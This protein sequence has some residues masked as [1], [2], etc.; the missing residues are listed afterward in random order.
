MT[1]SF[2]L[3]PALDLLGGRV[4]R[5]RQGDFSAITTYDDPIEA[6]VTTAARFADGLH[7][8]DLDGA[9]DGATANA[10]LIERL[11]ALSPVPIEVGGGLRTEADVARALGQGMARVILGSRAVE[12]PGF[13]R[14]MVE[15]YGPARIVVGADL[16]DGRPAVRGWTASAALT[17]DA[18]LQAMREAGVETVIVTDVATDGMMEGPNTALL[19]RLASA[20]PDLRIIASGGVASVADLD[21]L[22]A[23]GTAGAVFGRAW[24]DGVL[25]PDDLIA[26]R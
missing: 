12:D 1:S 16:R 20:F 8:V 19:G 15:E 14:A 18:F 23:A 7:V 26:F 25:A 11:V 5:L 3:W 2:E 13:V 17:A 21:A 9:R 6:L 24:L 10:P 4:V 22:R